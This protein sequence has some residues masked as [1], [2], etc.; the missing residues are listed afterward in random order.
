MGS[1]SGDEDNF[2]APRQKG[3]PNYIPKEQIFKNITA[4]LDGLRTKENTAAVN[5]N[6]YPTLMLELNKAM[7]T[8][9]HT[10]D[11]PVKQENSQSN[12]VSSNSSISNAFKCDK[13][14]EK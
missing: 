5:M 1:P 14:I 9:N 6:A 12:L 2:M 3:L 7:N 13:K 10:N 4:I 8:I 11:N